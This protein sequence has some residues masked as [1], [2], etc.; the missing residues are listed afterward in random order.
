MLIWEHTNT[1]IYMIYI[2]K[3]ITYIASGFKMQLLTS[4]SF[5]FETTSL[6]FQ[7]KTPQQPNFITY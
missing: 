5:V 4:S 6:R 3:M 2:N 7:L 1:Y